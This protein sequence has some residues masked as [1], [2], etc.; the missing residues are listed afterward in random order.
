MD[1]K[2]FVTDE[3]ARKQMVGTQ[4]RQTQSIASE[5]TGS[6]NAYVTNGSQRDARHLNNTMPASGIGAGT[7][8]I[9]PLGEDE[10]AKHGTAAAE[11]RSGP[12]GQKINMEAFNAYYNTQKRDDS[13]EPKQTAG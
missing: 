13:K 8:Q 1:V 10:K 7:E 9:T 2:N 3:N 6:M 4:K 12:N 5:L 11:P